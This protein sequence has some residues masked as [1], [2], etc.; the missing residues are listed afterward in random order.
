MTVGRVREAARSHAQHGGNRVTWPSWGGPAVVT[1]LVGITLLA[2]MGLWRGI[3]FD[4]L[5]HFAFGGMTF[6]YAVKTIDYTT[7]HV[8]HGQTGAYF[9]LD[10]ALLQVFGASATALRSPSLLAAFLLLVAAAA[11]LRAKGFGWRWQALVVLSLGANETLMFYTGEAR[12]YMPLAGSAAVMLAFY[13]LNTDERRKWWARAL[14]LFGFL[15]GSVMHPYWLVMWGLIAVFSLGVALA[16]KS[17]LRSLRASWI[18]LAPQYVLPALILYVVV[19]QLTW[20]RRV[21]NFG[22][23]NSIYNWG[24][25]WNAFLQNHFSFAPFIYPTRGGTGELDAGPI[26]PIATA[27][28]V[29]LTVSWLLFDRYARSSRLLA[30]VALFIVGA[31]SSLFFSYLSI[32]SQYIIFE[33]QWV[34]GMAITAIASTWFFAEWVRNNGNPKSI[35]QLPAYAFISLTIIAFSISMTSQVR[36]TLDR[37]ENWGA[38]ESDNRSLEELARAAINAET[39][40][41]DPRKPEDGYGYLAN[42]NIARGGPVWEIFIAWYNKE[43]GLRQEYRE[44]DDNWS[45]LIWPDPAPQSYLCLPEREWQCSPPPVGIK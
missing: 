35:R 14:A 17:E 22:W 39:F 27:A 37:Y 11:F 4:E 20:M 41:Y 7:T 38:V 34:A 29:I 13:A 33:R 1:A 40:S 32:R 2:Y 16:E 9:L 28:M 21:I 43:A 24:S 19:G 44:Q 45:D 26:I 3:W 25:L 12:P 31:G 15:V 18:F 8:N 23:D 42:V 30:P 6:E 10:W 36:I 5:L